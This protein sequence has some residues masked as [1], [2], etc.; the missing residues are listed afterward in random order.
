MEKILQ[1]KFYKWG[2][3]SWHFEEYDSYISK[4]HVQKS[5]QIIFAQLIEYAS[6]NGN[7]HNKCIHIQS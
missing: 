6:G 1:E 7:Y 2:D 4:T 3:I 5:A